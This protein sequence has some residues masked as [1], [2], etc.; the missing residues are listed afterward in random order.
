MI[1]AFEGNEFADIAITK[2]LGII[3]SANELNRELTEEETKTIQ[4]TSG[5]VGQR[6]A[7]LNSLAEA[8]KTDA[9]AAKQFNLLGGE[10]NRLAFTLF[11]EAAGRLLLKLPI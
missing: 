8:A 10:G 2:A 7:I 4:L 9:E 6:L 11:A 5:G 1:A 3:R